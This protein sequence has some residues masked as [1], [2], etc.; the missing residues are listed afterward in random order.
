MD[1]PHLIVGIGSLIAGFTELK[2]S[3]DGSSQKFGNFGKTAA[4]LTIGKP[5]SKGYKAKIYNVGNIDS[6]VAYI[7]KSIQKGRINPEI[8]AFAVKAVSQKCGSRWCVPERDW[9]GEVQAVF[10]AIRDNVRYVRDIHKVDTFQAPQRTLEFSGG[11]CDDYAITLGSALQSIGYPIKIRIVQS[12]DSSDYNHIFLLVGMPP[13]DP[14]KWYSLDAS[15]NKQPGWHPP[16]S[17][18]SRIKD[19]EVS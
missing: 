19:Y 10:K 8:R 7:I 15:L 13:R 17:M 4:P 5:G 18:L 11:D 12:T 3:I 2:K 1:V 14:S 9:W 6:R 16:R